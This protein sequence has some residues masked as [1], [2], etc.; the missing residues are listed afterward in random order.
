MIEIQG[1]TIFLIVNRRQ[2]QL[3][4]EAK[5]GL[6]RKAQSSLWPSLALL[7]IFVMVWTLYGVISAAPA[8]IHNDM[9]EAYAWGR[10]FQLGYEK[11]PPFW[12][13]IAGLWFEVFPRT[14]WAFTL[15]AVLNAGLGLY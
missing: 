10:E 12:A 8:A 1:L 5:K 14:D 13:W 11:H 2:P 7:A 6:T 3:S 15:L 4:A 9:A